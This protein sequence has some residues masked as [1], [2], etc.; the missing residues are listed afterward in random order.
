[1]G[2]FSIFIGDKELSMDEILIRLRNMNEEKAVYFIRSQLIKYVSGSNLGDKES[3][4]RELLE[5]K[6]NVLIDKYYLEKNTEGLI[7]LLNAQGHTSNREIFTIIASKYAILGKERND[8]IFHE[9]AGYLYERIDL[10][11]LAAN[12]YFLAGKFKLA[13]IEYKAVKNW[14]KSAEMYKLAG[15]PDYANKMME[16]A[17]GK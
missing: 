13:A 16:R 12:E 7:K 2:I 9:K 10:H 15:K 1:M 14:L 4:L 11:E 8:L 5:E 6:Q 3:K 17:Q